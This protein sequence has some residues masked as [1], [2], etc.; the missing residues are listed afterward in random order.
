MGETGGRGDVRTGGGA[1]RRGLSHWWHQDAGVS[2]WQLAPDTGS[3]RPQQLPAFSDLWLYDKWRLH[4]T[5]CNHPVCVSCQYIDDDDD[6][7]RRVFDLTLVPLHW[8]D[9]TGS[10]E[11]TLGKKLNFFLFNNSNVW[12]RY[13]DMTLTVNVLYLLKN[14]P[15]RNLCYFASAFILNCRSHDLTSWKCCNN[16]LFCSILP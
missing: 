3:Q 2:A 5:I 9:N 11:T 4:V 6:D 16:L 14:L 13:S 1:V 15:P 10:R 12:L 8:A 7:G